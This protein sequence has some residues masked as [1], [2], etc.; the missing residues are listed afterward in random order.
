MEQLKKT[1]VVVLAATMILAAL[2]PAYT[3][4]AQTVIAN[5]ASQPV[6]ADGVL[7]EFEAYNINDFNYFK[8]RDLAY[9]INGTGKQV[10]VGWS[11]A[12][13]AILLQAG[14]PTQQSTAIWQKATVQQRT[15]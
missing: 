2:I 4:A 9:I 11:E 1:L 7:T 15:H 13:N 3:L 5:P 10:S 14:S 6:Y 8:L 12:E